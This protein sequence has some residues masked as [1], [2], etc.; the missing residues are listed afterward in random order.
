MAT[1][2]VTETPAQKKNGNC[3]CDQPQPSQT[4]CQLICFE[5]PNYY[6]GHLLTDADLMLDQRYVREKNKLYHRALD[7]YGVVCGLRLTCDLDCEG[8]I[9]VGKG[10]AIDDCGND[11]IVCERTRFDV[12]QRL[13]E[14]GYV[15]EAM[16]ADPCEPEPPPVC[17]VPQCFYVTICYRETESEFT[18]PFVAGCRPKLSECEPSRVRETVTFDVVN[19][20]PETYDP[21][22]A[23]EKRL[24]NCFKLFSEG[25]FADALRRH[26]AALLALISGKETGLSKERDEYW[27]M[28]CELRGLFL[29]YLKRCPD[30]YNCGLE[31]EIRAIRTAWFEDS[32]PDGTGNNNQE[33]G[34]AFCRLL[35]LAWQHAL[36]CVFGELIPRCAE[37]AQS[38]C[39]VLGTVK[40]ENGQLVHVCNCPRSYVWSPAN[41]TEVLLATVL[42]G[43]AC[44]ADYSKADPE[45]SYNTITKREFC[46]R[47]FELD[48]LCLLRSLGA[49]SEAPFFSGIA[50][51]RWIQQLIASLRR[52]LDFTD[53]CRF[54][55]Q[56]Y[57]GMSREQADTATVRMG[58]DATY[59]DASPSES[60]APPLAEVIQ[61]PPLSSI[62]ESMV[63]TVNERGFVTRA[64]AARAASPASSDVLNELTAVKKQLAAVIEENRAN[65]AKFKEQVT[66]L[67][68]AIGQS[69][70]PSAV[71]GK[72]TAAPP[73]ARRAKKR[74]G[75]EPQ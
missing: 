35:E 1:Q 6:C 7:G 18:T 22:N 64:T 34:N 65:M 16:P 47:E 60:E 62:K 56:M 73:G 20:L 49:N 10:F 37:P 74:K 46:C 31:K 36:S 9:M 4:C 70:T 43:L 14:K 29:L 28:F 25:A 15:I 12:L 42:G 23:L 27:D 41:F 8:Q 2:Y 30:R 51:F 52:G 11:L 58:A 63:F 40:V 50:S 59:V 39:V 68:N 45:G 26:N 72:E 17:I 67:Q 71:S 24:K 75:G 54:S 55:P 66:S 53:A 69:Q 13:R 21:L 61:S 32:N 5:R 44:E 33:I 3:S 57:R 48:C 38:S 19:E